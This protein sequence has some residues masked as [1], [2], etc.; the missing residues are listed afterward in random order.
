MHASRIACACVCVCVCMGYWGID[1]KCV[2]ERASKRI[3]EFV[4]ACVSPFKKICERRVVRTHFNKSLREGRGRG[5][6]RWGW[7]SIWKKSVGVTTRACRALGLSRRR[8]FYFSDVTTN[9]ARRGNFWKFV[10]VAFFGF[11]CNG[12]DPTESRSSTS[13]S[14]S[15]KNRRLGSIFDSVFWRNEKIGAL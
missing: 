12:R 14:S 2:F 5:E 13:S 3:R 1:V 4:C 9:V 7:V 10:D 8:P 11:F 15:S 6:G